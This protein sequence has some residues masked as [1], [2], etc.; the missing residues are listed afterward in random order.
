MKARSNVN[1]WW[2]LLLWSGLLVVVVA[3]SAEEQTCTAEGVCFNSDEE[4]AKH[5]WKGRLV[6][7]NFGEP[8]QVAGEEWKKTLDVIAKTKEYMVQVRTNAT[9][10]PLVK[11]CKLR[12]PLC[13][14]WAAI[15]MYCR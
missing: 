12:N 13:S 3:V 8:Q 2:L 15:G 11:E 4:A 6:D 7:V 10:A 5:Y 9:M 1:A 14:F